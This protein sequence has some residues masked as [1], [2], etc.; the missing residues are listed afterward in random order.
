MEDD[1]DVALMLD[2][3]RGDR[4][5]FERLLRKHQDPVLNL[6]Y[7]FLGDRDEAEDLAQEIFLRVYRA[8]DSYR[9][10]ARFAT[11]LYRIAANACL[12]ALR[13]RRNR[14]SVSIQDIEVQGESGHLADDAKEATP[15]ESVLRNEMAERIREI[16]DGLPD[17]QRLAIVLNKYQ[18]LSYEEVAESMSLS[19]MAVK[20]LLFRARERIRERLIPYLR[21]EVR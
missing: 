8:R 3:Q 7:R 20:S 21:E 16:V 13:A 6:A 9:P 4:K 2:V 1:A 15:A 17:T 18:G 19:V 14:R 11:W 12:N 5:A 10:E